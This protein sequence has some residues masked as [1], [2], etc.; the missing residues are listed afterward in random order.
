MLSRVASS[1]YW[2]GRY[3]ERSDFLGRFLSINYFSSLDSPNSISQSRRFVLES[4]LFMWGTDFSGSFEEDKILFH[5]GFDRDN[6]NSI[7]S[8]VTN[9]RQNAHG[10]RHLISSETWE[11]INKCYHFVNSYSANVFIQSGLYDLTTKLNESCSV[12]REK[13]VRTLLHDEVFALIMLGIHI[14]RAFQMVRLINTKIHDIDKIMYDFSK[15]R[16]DMAHEW[17]TLLRCAEAYDMSKKYYKRI[18]D[19]LKTIEFLVLNAQ[20]PKSLISNINKTKEYIERIS[21]KNRIGPGMVEFEIGKM[22]AHFN[23]LS[24]EEIAKNIPEFLEKTHDGLLS[25]GN[26]FEK[27]YLVF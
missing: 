6:P 12:I 1:L 26:Q 19:K 13:V 22:A 27:E 24:M 18:P 7:L 5:L 16:P 2:T 10:T 15:G 21:N 23:Y 14:E 17:A 3:V 4:M 9:A 8:A 11:A 25:I 20:N